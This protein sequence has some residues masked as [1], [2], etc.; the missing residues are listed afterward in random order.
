MLQEMEPHA[1]ALA[2]AAFRGML[3]ELKPQALLISGESGAGKTE[4]VKRACVVV[5]RSSGAAVEHVLAMANQART[6]DEDVR[7]MVVNPLLKALGNAKTVRNG[8]SSR[9]GKW[10]EIQFDTTGFITASKITSYLLEKPITKCPR[11]AHH[12]SLYQLCRGAT[13]EQRTH[14]QLM[15]ATIPLHWRWCCGASLDRR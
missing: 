15:D 9:F 3:V 2:E 4:A 12:H 7:N 11:R 13:A 6:Q 5:A 8:N 10:I 1:Y 14:L